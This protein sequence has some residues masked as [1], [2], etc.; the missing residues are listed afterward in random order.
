MSAL[1]SCSARVL[2]SE[3]RPAV[4][5]PEALHVEVQ[6]QA[7]KGMQ[8]EWPQRVACVQKHSLHLLREACMTSSANNG[9]THIRLL[10]NQRHALPPNAQEVARCSRVQTYTLCTS[11]RERALQ[12]DLGIAQKGAEVPGVV[13]LQEGQRGRLVPEHVLPV[14]VVADAGVPPFAPESRPHRRSRLHLPVRPSVAPVIPDHF[15]H[16]GPASYMGDPPPTP[17]DL[18]PHRG[19]CPP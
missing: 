4:S 2:L 6:I 12:D 7:S 16:G 18:L 9:K 15:A 5:V 19:T 3:E 1:Q 17:G 13:R 10:A 11:G 14:R 8:Q